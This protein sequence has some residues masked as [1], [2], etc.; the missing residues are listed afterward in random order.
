MSSR[1]I[2]EKIPNFKSPCK[3]D[4]QIIIDRLRGLTQSTGAKTTMLSKKVTKTLKRSI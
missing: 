3:K 4:L 1:N 2:K